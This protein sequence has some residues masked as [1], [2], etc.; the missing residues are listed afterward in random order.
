MSQAPTAGAC[1]WS[2]L[3]LPHRLGSPAL[4]AGL[5]WPDG[6]GVRRPAVVGQAGHQRIGAVEAL[7]GGERAGRV[8]AEVRAPRESLAREAA[9]RAAVAGEQ[10]A[11]HAPCPRRRYRCPRRTGRRRCGAVLLAIVVRCSCMLPVV[12]MPP[13]EIDAVLPLIVAEKIPVLVL[14]WPAIAPPTAARLRGHRGEDEAQVAAVEDA[15]AA[16]EGD[17]VPD[18]RVVRGELRA[19]LDRMPPPIGA[20]PP[21]M[22][23]PASTE[24]EPAGTWI[25]R[26]APR[27]SMTV[28]RAPAAGVAQEAHAEHGVVLNT[29]RA[30]REPVDA[31][32][33]TRTH[34]PADWSASA[35]ASRSVQ[36]RAHS[37][38]LP[39][40]V[41]STTRFP[42]C[43]AAAPGSASA[44]SNAAAAAAPSRM[45][46]RRERKP[47]DD[48]CG[49]VPSLSS[50]PGRL[51][52]SSGACDVAL[53]ALEGH[54][55][56]GFEVAHL[57]PAAHHPRER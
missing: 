38:S 48:G 53:A 43:G 23:T 6:V 34:W 7:T 50:R 36:S 24:L 55:L 33:R 42:N 41:V 39:S 56:P 28:D 20:L 35:T 37:P 2:G 10:R 45:R 26:L 14:A 49:V 51:D 15:A 22:V 13:P 19:V 18:D 17:V 9:A 40:A 44:T 57:H 54:G 32:A 4:I 30:E 16:L 3:P 52:G 27:A 12:A 1:R 25:T 5:P 29:Q 46:P 11:P 47:S 31:R 8:V 21:V